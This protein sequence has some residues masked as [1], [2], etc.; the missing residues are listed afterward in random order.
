MISDELYGE[1]VSLRIRA[2]AEKAAEVAADAAFDRLTFPEK[3]GLCVQAEREARSA[4]RTARLN[5]E[6][7]F[8][9]PAACVEDIEYM[10]GRS[11]RRDTIERLAECAFISDKRNVIIHSATGAG[12][13][14]VSQAIGNAACRKGR[15]VRYVRHPDM[16]RETA[17]ARSNGGLYECMDAFSSVDLLV[18]DDLFLTETPM[19]AVTDLL[20]IV[21]SR[22]G[23]GSLLIASQ[24]TPEEWHLRIDTKI[25]A[26]ALLDRIVHNSHVIEI[27]GPNMREYFAAKGREE[28]S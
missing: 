27:V 19:Q 8:S 12:K 11:I 21:E 26:D 15:S 25:I 4:R 22:I 7:R 2:F 23:K 5:R 17:I 28:P 6:A 18:L 10:P 24:L 13:S 1:M 20:E 16:A 3:I 14:Y 9:H